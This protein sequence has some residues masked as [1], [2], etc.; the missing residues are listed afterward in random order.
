MKAQN[1]SFDEVYDKFA[2]ESF[3]NQ[4][5]TKKSFLLGKYIYRNRPL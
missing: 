3:T 5:H 1:V 2:L 4:T